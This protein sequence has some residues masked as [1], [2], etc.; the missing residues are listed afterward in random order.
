MNSRFV[1]P[2]TVQFLDGFNHR[3]TYT[4]HTFAAGTRAE[5]F[6]ISNGVGF[7]HAVAVEYVL[8]FGRVGFPFERQKNGINLFGCPRFQ[9]GGII[10]KT[11]VF[12]D[13]GDHAL[14]GDFA[15]AVAFYTVGKRAFHVV[16]FRQ[17][18]TAVALDDVKANAGFHN[19]RKIAVFFQSKSRVFKYFLVAINT[20]KA[21]ITTFCYRS[22]I[23]SV[24]GT[25]VFPF[26]ASH[27]CL[28]ST[29]GLH[30]RLIDFFRRIA[31]ANQ[32]LAYFHL[33]AC[34]AEAVHTNDVVSGVRAHGA[35][36]C[37]GLG[38]VNSLLK[39]VIAVG[40]HSSYKTDVATIVFC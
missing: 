37:A 22:F 19:F 9:H 39:I 38:R 3:Y 20:K 28:I 11:G 35:N 23:F 29:V 4:T 31:F 21:D 25:N 10:L 12:V 36:Q 2:G 17:R 27:H 32:Y 8:W 6:K 1:C 14:A 7:F 26:A 34:R 18:A 5:I 24:F 16:K 15:A 33:A 40:Q 30:T 13:A